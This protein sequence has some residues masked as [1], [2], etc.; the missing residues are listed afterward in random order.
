MMERMPIAGPWI[1]QRGIDYVTDGARMPS[2]AITLSITSGLKKPLRNTLAYDRP[3]LSPLARQPFISRWT[4]R[5]LNLAMKSF[6][7]ISPGTQQ[8]RQYAISGQRQSFLILIPKAGDF[9]PHRL[10]N[11]SRRIPELSFSWT[12]M[13]WRKNN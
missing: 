8:Q 11:A 12:F 9:Q 3:L 5:G 10:R 2:T 7:P 1:T 4:P 6:Y 13:A